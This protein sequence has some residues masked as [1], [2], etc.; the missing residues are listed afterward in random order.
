MAGVIGTQKFS[1]DIWRDTVNVASRM[2]SHG[3]PGQ[4]HVS[5]AARRAIGRRFRFRERGQVMVKGKG[6][7]NTHFLVGRAAPA[8]APPVD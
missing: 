2:E 8:D 7:M 4:L 1:C 5:D 3:L 6:R